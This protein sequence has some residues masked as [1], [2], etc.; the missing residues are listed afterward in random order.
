MQQ[1]V[2]RITAL[3]TELLDEAKDVKKRADDLHA[4]LAANSI[5]QNQDGALNSK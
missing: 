5:E 4:K 1:K 2:D 3:K